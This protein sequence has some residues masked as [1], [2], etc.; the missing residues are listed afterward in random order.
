M[1]W[2]EFNIEQVNTPSESLEN[3]LI[4]FEK[5]T[6]GLLKLN[7]FEKSEMERMRKKYRAS[8]QYDLILHSQFMPSYKFEIL[9]L[10]Y[11]VTLYPCA[12]ILESGI[13]EEIEMNPFEQSISLENEG[14]LKKILE[15]IFNTNRF[16]SIVAG[17]MKITS[18]SNKKTQDDLPF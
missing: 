4:G 6:K 17:L 1:E 9:E 10:L 12:L 16:E 15:K 11:D 3:A 5:A 8:F 14:E 18:V 13:R 7:L 2:K